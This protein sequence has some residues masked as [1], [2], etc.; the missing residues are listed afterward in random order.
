MQRKGRRAF[1]ARR[2]RCGEC[3]K[4]VP[5]DS[6]LA[7]KV[8]VTTGDGRTLLGRLRRQAAEGRARGR[9]LAV[10]QVFCTNGCAVAALRRQ[11]EVHEWMHR[12][13]P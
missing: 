4:L 9:M 12:A 10:P 1:V 2:S 7:C 3:G 6:D 8:V 5:S 11:I 13:Q